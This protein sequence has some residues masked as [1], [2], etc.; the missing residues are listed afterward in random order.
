MNYPLNDPWFALRRF[1][2]M[3][4]PVVVLD[5]GANVG[6]TARRA[7]AVFPA[8][9]IHAF[10]PDADV[11]ETLRDRTRHLPGV[12]AH[13]LALGDRTGEAQLRVA[14]NSWC[15]GMLPAGDAAADWYGDW[16]DV[17][18][19]RSVPLTTLDAL[20][21]ELPLPRADILKLDVQGFEGPVLAG[22]R[23]VL[24]RGGP[25]GIKAV[26]AEAHLAPVYR[27]ATSFADIDRTLRDLGFALHRVLH[28]EHR[29]HEHQATFL[30][31]LWLRGDLM[32]DLRARAAADMELS[33]RPWFRA[34]LRD[35]AA[36]GCRRAVILGAGQHTR[37]VAP[38]LA[39]NIVHVVAIADDRAGDA[40]PAKRPGP[41]A[42]LPIVSINAALDLKPDAVVLSSSVHEPA[43]WARA[44]VF[45]DRGIHVARVH[46]S[47]E[48][49]PA[50]A[51]WSPE[52]EWPAATQTEHEA[53]PDARPA[54]AVAA[55]PDAQ[56]DID[57]RNTAYRRL[58]QRRLEHLATLPIN[59]SARSVLEVGAGVGELTGF[60]LD[61][62]CRI[63]A[64]DG[65]PDQP[66][67]ILRAF[68]DH[69]LRHNLSASTIDLDNPPS[70][71][72]VAGDGAAARFDLVFSYGTLYHL[73]NPLAALQFFA[74]ACSHALLL[75]TCVSMADGVRLNPVSEPSQTRSQSK[76]GWGCRPTR[77]WVFEALHRFFPHVYVTAT[78]PPHEQFPL[79]WRPGAARGAVPP[80]AMG[81]GGE[82]LARCVF[83]A[84]HQPI[85][86]PLLLMHLPD[87]QTL[88]AAAG[89]LPT[90]TAPSVL[91][92]PRTPAA[93]AGRA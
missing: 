21:R 92:E 85:D 86:H 38:V 71:V 93:I 82:R 24:S 19:T 75:E 56:A 63:H 41:I 6:E 5:V 27:G 47:A 32:A 34:A 45:R 29:G 44:Q 14:R 16:F 64:T 88:D 68:A 50:W 46:T 3:W 55:S 35:L 87:V 1:L 18:S 11:C 7:A 79:D 91:A 59:L 76:S 77:Q 74:R 33:P 89:S 10:E 26:I 58:N 61:R 49:I 54:A 40:D 80:G 13:A 53:R 20:A 23:E 67:L 73:Q 28:V 43:L 66:P 60:F 37:D 8:A 30:D 52:A 57:F 31:G 22:A 51:A 84:S 25:T 9:T 90:P 2:P 62:G 70:S 39:E 15:T 48:P 36:R 65:R 12:R 81:F 42:G 72:S 83:V 78:Q 4:A 69:H 17:V